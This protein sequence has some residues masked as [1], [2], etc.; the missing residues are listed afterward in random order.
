MLRYAADGR[1]LISISLP[2]KHLYYCEH[3]SHV[4]IV[5]SC[6]LAYRHRLPRVF[7][8]LDEKKFH[9]LVHVHLQLQCSEHRLS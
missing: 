7:R 3:L 9:R 5:K 1:C 8:G 4:T 2:R 6:V